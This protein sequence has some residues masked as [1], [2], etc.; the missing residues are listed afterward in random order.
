MRRSDV[1]HPDVSSAEFGGRSSVGRGRTG[2]RSVRRGRA[3]LPDGRRRLRSWTG[4]AL[5]R[6]F[7]GANVRL[8][9]TDTT[10]RHGIVFCSLDASRVDVVLAARLALGL[11][12][13]FSRMRGYD[14]I[15]DGAR[16]VAWTARTR[17]PGRRWTS[18]RIAIR[19]GRQ[20]PVARRR[21]TRWPRHQGCPVKPPVTTAVSSPFSPCGGTCTPRCGGGRCPCPTLTGLGPV[22]RRRC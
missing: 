11:P 7:L 4:G 6:S 17:W 19:V 9:S 1:D 18:G 14:R 2:R 16:E 10:G 3:G 21:A 12:H 5:L 8:Y 15:H 22:A 20:L 13:C